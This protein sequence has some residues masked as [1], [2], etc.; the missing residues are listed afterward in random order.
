M[1][2][3]A[4][5]ITGLRHNGYFWSIVRIGNSYYA[6][7]GDSDTGPYSTASQAVDFIK[8]IRNA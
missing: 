7:Q 2:E 6:R 5:Y 8:E 1:P 4:R 3:Q